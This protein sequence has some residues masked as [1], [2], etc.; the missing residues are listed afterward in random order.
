MDEQESFPLQFESGSGLTGELLE[1]MERTWEST[2]ELVRK[3]DMVLSS[4]VTDYSMFFAFFYFAMCMEPDVIQI[5]RCI[6]M[7]IEVFISLFL[8]VRSF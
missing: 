3:Y 8:G 5:V 2:R 7:I 4:K 1:E 6:G